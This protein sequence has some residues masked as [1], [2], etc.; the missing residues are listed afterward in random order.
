[1]GLHVKGCE[2]CAT[3]SYAVYDGKRRVAGTFSSRHLAE[4]ARERLEREARRR[5]RPCL[6]CGAP[7]E[8]EGAHHRMCKGCREWAAAQ[9]PRMAG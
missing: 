7:F 3:Y 5:V 1:M 8:S 9:D 4:A 2:G 6:C